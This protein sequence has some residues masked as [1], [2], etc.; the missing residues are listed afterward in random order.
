[1]SCTNSTAA[2]LRPPSPDTA[3]REHI[4]GLHRGLVGQDRTGTV[5]RLAEAL[6][7]YRVDLGPRQLRR[8]LKHLRAGYRRTALTVRYKQD[9]A[10]VACAEAV[11]ENPRA[12]AEAGELELFSQDESGFAPSLP[13]AMA[14]PG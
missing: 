12:K 1:M 11:L 4:T 14:G 2:G 9:P 6:R 13:Y 7:A 8:Y 5:A 10:E 3:R